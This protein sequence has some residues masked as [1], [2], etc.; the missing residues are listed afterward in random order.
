M[1]TK[2]SWR[3]ALCL[4]VS[5]SPAYSQ[6]LSLEVDG[7]SITEA[8]VMDE[9]NI[10]VRGHNLCSINSEPMLVTLGTTGVID[11]LESTH[12][13]LWANVNIGLVTDHLVSLLF[14]SLSE[15]DVSF[16]TAS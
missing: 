8:F 16:A 12:R 2:L 1:R 7:M 13:E 10:V 15:P 14:R 9:E 3:L 6:D 4:L 5:S 11:A